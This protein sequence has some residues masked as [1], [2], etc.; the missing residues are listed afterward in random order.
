M[1]PSL[2]AKVPNDISAATANTSSTRPTGPTTV[3]AAHRVRLCYRDEAYRQRTEVRTKNLIADAS[4]PT[5]SSTSALL[6]KKA[7][8]YRKVYDRMTGVD[9]NDP[10]FD[11][12]E[13]ANI[14]AGRTAIQRRPCCGVFEWGQRAYH[15]GHG[16]AGPSGVDQ[17]VLVLTRLQLGDV[18]IAPTKAAPDVV[19][20][21][22]VPCG[23]SCNGLQAKAPA[24]THATEVRG[25]AA[26][27]AGTAACLVASETK[28][29]AV[30]SRFTVMED[31]CAAP[32][33]SARDG[34]H[35]DS[36]T[37]RQRREPP[38]ADCEGSLTLDLAGSSARGS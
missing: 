21:A 35:P 10:N 9:V 34:W 1:S 6:A 19:S 11:V 7:L 32:M 33:V 25:T 26:P 14:S 4:L 17:G 37:E 5:S 29:T 16:I 27:A 2:T 8:K 30:K 18:D 28:I 12:F 24:G 23:R 3:R 31:E 36:R 38:S 22:K 13:K 15:A 20:T